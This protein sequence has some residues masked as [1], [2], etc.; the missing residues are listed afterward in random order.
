MAPR[1]HPD[2]VPKPPPYD[3]R[4]EGQGKCY[5]NDHSGNVLNPRTRR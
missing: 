3:V 2:T 5:N 4:V 1:V